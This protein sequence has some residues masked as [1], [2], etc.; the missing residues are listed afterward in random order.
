MSRRAILFAVLLAAGCTRSHYRNA[1]DREVYPILAERMVLPEYDIGRTLVDPAPESRLFDATDPDRPPLPPDDPAAAGF[2]ARPNGMK[3]SRIWERHGRA[4]DIDPPGWEFFLSPDEKGVVHL[5]QTRAV[6]IALANSR[7]YQT[8]LETVY[9]SALGLTLNRFEFDLRWFLRN[10]TTYTHFGS[11]PTETNTLQVDTNLGFAKNFAA[12]GQLLIDFANSLVY[13]YTGGSRQFRSNLVGVMTQP[14]LRNFGRYVRLEQLTQAERNV[15]YAVRDF[16]R[17]RKAFWA[18]TAVQDGGY[19]DLLLALQTLRNNQANYKAQEETY[20]LYAELFRGG[21]ASVV[22]FDQFFQSLQTSKLAVIDAQVGLETALD[23]FKLRLGVPPRIPIQLDDSLLNQFVFVDPDTEKLRDELAAFQQSRLKELG[24][25]PPVAMLDE[26]FKALRAH[27]D[28][29]PMALERALLDLKKWNERLDL[30][31]KPSEDPEQRERQRETYQTIAKLVGEIALD[32]KKIAAAI[33]KHRKEVTEQT[34][35]ES[36][37]NVTQDTKNLL[38]QLDTII[39]LQTTARTYLIELPEVEMNEEEALLIAK[40]SRFDLQNQR[41][42]VVD[43]WRKMKVAINALWAD[44]NLVTEF[45]IG[46]DPDHL[47]PLAFASEN[48]RYAVGLRF[49]GPLNRLA[50]RNVYRASLIFYQRARRDYM[51]LSDRIEFQVRQDLRQL[52][53]LRVGFEVARQ[54]LLSAARQVENNRLILT[55]PMDKRKAN[56]VTTINLLRALDSFLIARNGLASSYVNFEQQ[57]IQLLLDLEEL[58]LDERGFPYEYQRAATPL[59][60]A[61]AGT[62]VEI[63]TSRR[64]PD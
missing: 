22:E 34:R 3:G 51:A 37:E 21:R 25:P 44:L 32:L 15:L 45:N 14:L 47:N 63:G 13:E 31:I 23:N 53:R 30:P 6:E 50:E 8:A 49:D 39:T 64:L 5:D 11:G 43:A 4:S 41:A 38:A 12:G 16:A 62:T 33:D 10:N 24:Q 59:P 46:T 56:D 19:L 48:S 61:G 36:W 54:T 17:F 35:K 9:L 40:E 55:G 2:M 28:Q 18:Q 60:P 7:E 29:V 27:A 20:R 57:R 52:N 26:Q 1:A 58:Q 42:I